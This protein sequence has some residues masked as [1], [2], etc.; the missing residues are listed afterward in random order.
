MNKEFNLRTKE[1]EYVIVILNL[2]VI[3]KKKAKR[4]LR[5]PRIIEELFDFIFIMGIL[6]SRS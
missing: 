5:N 4:P 6:N 3:F 1:L 2:K